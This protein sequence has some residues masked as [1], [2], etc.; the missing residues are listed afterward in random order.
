MAIF[1]K[2]IPQQGPNRR[3]ILNDQDRS[4]VSHPLTRRMA[5]G[6][7]KVTSNPLD[8]IMLLAG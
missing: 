8:G 1:F 3:V 4:H 5:D 6:R 7:L 2:N